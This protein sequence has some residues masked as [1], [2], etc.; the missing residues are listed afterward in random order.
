MPLA[1]PKVVDDGRLGP[2]GKDDKVLGSV[3]L[4]TLKLLDDRGEFVGRDK[5]PA[6]DDADILVSVLYWLTFELLAELGAFLVALPTTTNV[7]TGI[8]GLAYG[9]VVRLRG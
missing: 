6:S 2:P 1:E 4:K 9:H 8:L 7:I 5:D 3:R